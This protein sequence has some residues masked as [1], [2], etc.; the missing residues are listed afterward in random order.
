MRSTATEIACTAATLALAAGG[1]TAAFWQGLTVR[2]YTVLTPKLPHGRRLRAVVLSDV[3]A[4]RYGVSQQKLMDRVATQNPDMILITGDLFDERRDFRPAFETASG[5]VAVAPTFYVRG[6]HEA[7]LRGYHHAQILRDLRRMGIVTPFG[8]GEVRQLRGI[9]VT[10]CGVSDP[11]CVGEAHSAREFASASE[12]C[13]SHPDVLSIL[14]VHRPA[15][16]SYLAGHGF[17][18]VF[19]G[20]AHGGQWRIPGLVNGL[21]APGQGFLPQYAG[22]LYC[23]DGTAEIISRGLS[24]MFLYPRLCNPPELVVTDFV[25]FSQT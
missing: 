13:T 10:V 22:G 16:L 4:T 5:A 23:A 21:Y 2:R 6:N 14:L 9:P 24:R 18:A 12:F 17:D 25:G 1:A 20:H 7:R 8:A 3:H 11:E 15:P 19:A